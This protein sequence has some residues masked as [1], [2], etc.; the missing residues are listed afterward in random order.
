MGYRVFVDVFPPKTVEVI[1]QGQ[2][3]QRRLTEPLPGEAEHYDPE[4]GTLTV[5][6]PGG[7][8]W[9]IVSV[10]TKPAPDAMLTVQRLQDGRYE[11]LDLPPDPEGA[12]T[13]PYA[14]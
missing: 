7:K 3:L 13:E 14:A 2:T 8:V 5:R 10:H 12:G 6:F 1:I 9:T 11:F 4:R